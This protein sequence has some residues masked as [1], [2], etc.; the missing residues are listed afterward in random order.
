MENSTDN[1]IVTA[2]DDDDRKNVE[3]DGRSQNVR[4]VVHV[5][6]QAIE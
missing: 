4:L 6:G 5:G 2:N 1:E 3:K